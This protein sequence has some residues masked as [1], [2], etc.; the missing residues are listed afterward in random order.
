MEDRIQLVESKI[1]GNKKH[2]PSEDPVILAEA[3]ELRLKKN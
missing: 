1:D 2:R 3:F